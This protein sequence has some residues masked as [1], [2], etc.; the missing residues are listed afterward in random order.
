MQTLKW[1]SLVIF[2][3]CACVHASPTLVCFSPSIIIQFESAQA[4][5][6]VVQDFPSL[7]RGLMFRQALAENSGMLFVFPR[8]DFYSMWMKD[9]PLSLSIAFIDENEQIINID[10]MYP[11]SLNYHFPERPARYVV[12]MPSHWFELHHILPGQ[13]VQAIKNSAVL[14]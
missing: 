10:E 7:E 12:E 2:F 11:L 5:V 14:Y 8:S 6:E 4:C 13:F 1:V 3:S 9:T